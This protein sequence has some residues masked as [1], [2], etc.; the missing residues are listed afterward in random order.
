MDLHK[1]FSSE[2]NLYKLVKKLLSEE[3]IKPKKKL[4]QTFLID[5]EELEYLSSIL[6]KTIDK[7][8]CIVEIGA[9]IGNLTTYIASLN[10]DKIV[11]ALEID[12]R[13]ASVLRII[14]EAFPNVDI[15]I[16]DALK[17]IPSMRGCNVVVGNLPYH[18]TSSLLVAI[19]KSSFDL[20]LVTVQKEVAERVVAKAGSKN[21][22]KIAIFLQHLFEVTYV[23]TIPLYKFYPKPRVNSAIVLLKRKKAYDLMSQTLEHLIK[24]LFSFKRKTADKAL[25]RCLKEF[26]AS[27]KCRLQEIW[28]KRVYQLTV[29]ELERVAIACMYANQKT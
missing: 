24:C 4:S 19:A 12:E 20:A 22:G 11:V 2:R 18:I 23:K 8:Q 26:E 13:F 16:G 17:I 1:L 10:N 9:G 27:E 3:G 21:Y 6:R 7:Q 5:A 25:K 14:Q 29:E 15:V 28:R